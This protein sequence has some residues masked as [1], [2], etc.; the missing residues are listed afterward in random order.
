MS[1]E[2]HMI[3]CRYRAVLLLALLAPVGGAAAVLATFAF[4]QAKQTD[5][6]LLAKL[7]ELT[8]ERT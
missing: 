4:A 2:D 8:P 1:R 5:Q 6:Q 7:D 3:R